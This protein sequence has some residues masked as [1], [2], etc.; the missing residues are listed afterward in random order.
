MPTLK[1]AEIG[2]GSRATVYKSALLSEL[3]LALDPDLDLHGDGPMQFGLPPL[4]TL[5][6][7]ELETFVSVFVEEAEKRSAREFATVALGHRL[8]NMQE[9][10]LDELDQPRARV[11]V[12]ACHA[13]SKSFTAAGAVLW[14]TCSVG[15]IALTSAPT[16]R[17]ARK[18]LWSEIKKQY[19]RAREPLG[20]YMMKS[21]ELRYSD[22]NYA[23]GF[24]TDDPHNWH[25][26][27]AD[28]LLII[29]DEAPGIS[30]ETYDAIMGI[31]AGGDVR[32]LLL[33]NPVIVGGRFWRIF[34]ESEDRSRW[35]T[36]TIDA[37][38]TPNL[39]DL[40]LHD[41]DN[42]QEFVAL[43][44][45]SPILNDN[46]LPYLVTR[47]F[48]HEAYHEWGEENPQWQARVRGQFPEFDEYALYSLSWL[49]QARNRRIPEIDLLNAPF[50]GGL[51]V[52]G[53]GSDE[54]ALC[55]REGPKIHGIWGWKQ[56]DTK[57]KVL[58]LCRKYMALAAAKGK[59]FTLKVDA[60]GVGYHYALELKKAG[61][62]VTR[63][64]GQ[65]KPRDTE[66]F[67]KAKDEMYW[68]LRLALKDGR[69]AN[70]NDDTTISQAVSPRWRESPSTGK[71]EVESKEK[72]RSRGI[73]SP[74]RLEAV[75]FAFA[76]AQKLAP[77][78]R[79]RKATAG[80][81]FKRR[82]PF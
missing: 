69:V 30:D 44:H 75:V 24:S 14:W 29:L 80:Q 58:E 32:I 16:G 21:P 64:R 49:E 6:E 20:G 60:E 7:A 5:V 37:F 47:H 66:R 23:L 56:A 33:G 38:D 72:L 74:D 59:R 31:A 45:D 34:N 62:P 81:S 54:T 78:T 48:V 27:H 82:N 26:F 43:P 36:H 50:E 12:K 2:A 22:A 15:G 77:S 52:A 67:A 46:P 11:A 55:I 79:G 35:T 9:A 70:L 10:I 1:A 53:P 41:P 18:V 42:L 4:T 76:R 65:A 39:V 25:G 19:N 63:I 13:S 73:K 51:D 17:Q 68:D 57:E 28:K 3:D 8:W 40:D 61:I 71:I